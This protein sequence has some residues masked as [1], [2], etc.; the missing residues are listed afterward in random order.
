MLEVTITVSNS[1]EM[2]TELSADFASFEAFATVQLRFHFFWDMVLHCSLIGLPTTTV[3]FQKNRIL[4]W[5]LAVDV[6]NM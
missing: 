6:K 3:I 4:N 5:V 1:G 2:L